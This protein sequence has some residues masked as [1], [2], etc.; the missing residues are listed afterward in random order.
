MTGIL[1]LITFL[2]IVGVAAILALRLFAPA[3]ATG[4]QDRKRR[5]VDRAAVTTLAVLLPCP[6][7]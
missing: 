5:Q 1:S 6:W 2:P 3:Q 4:S 7:C